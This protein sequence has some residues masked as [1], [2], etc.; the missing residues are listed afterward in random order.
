MILFLCRYIHFCGGS[1]L[2]NTFV[3]TAAHCVVDVKIKR[4][5]V[6]VGDHDTSKQDKHERII[7]AEK[8]IIH[9][10]YNPN[11]FLNDIGMIT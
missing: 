11:N 2:S 1:A 8:I 7:A 3:I 5:Y 4:L 6:S 9:L 10:E